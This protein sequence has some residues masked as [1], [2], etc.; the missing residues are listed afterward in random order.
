MLSYLSVSITQI[1]AFAFNVPFSMFR[2]NPY[3]KNSVILYILKFLVLNT[4]HSYLW[5]LIFNFKNS[6]RTLYAEIPMNNTSPPRITAAAGTRFNQGFFLN[7]VIIFFNKRVLQ[8]ID[9]Q[10]THK[11][12][13]DQAFAHCPRFPTAGFERSLVRVSV[14]MW[15]C[16]LPDQLKIIGLVSYYLSNYLILHKLII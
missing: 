2:F 13:L 9:L 12:L 8:S 3:S 7:T 6:L 1:T 15:L 4:N 10:V 14:P 16:I 11:I 5:Y